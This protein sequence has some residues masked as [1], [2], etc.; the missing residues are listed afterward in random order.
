MTEQVPKYT[1]EHPCVPVISKLTPLVFQV[2]YLNQLSYQQPLE[3][4]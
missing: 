1:P 3:H 4:W 2:P